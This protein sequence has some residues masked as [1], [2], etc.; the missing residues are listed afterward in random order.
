MVDFVWCTCKMGKHNGDWNNEKSNFE[1]GR[2]IINLQM[3]QKSQVMLE[4]KCA[5]SFIKCDVGGWM[6]K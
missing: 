2:P 1:K 5:N 3:S 6:W 4:V